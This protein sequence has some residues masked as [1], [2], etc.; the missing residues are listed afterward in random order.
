MATRDDVISVLGALAH[1]YP[2]TKLSEG[3][4]D[5]WAQML[6]DIPRGPLMAG[7][8]L[9]ICESRFMPSISE[10]RNAAFDLMDNPEDR[11]TGVEAWEPIAAALLNC[12]VGGPVLS[13]RA[14]R[15]L[16]ITSGDFWGL[17]ARIQSGRDGGTA[18]RARFIEAYDSIRKREIREDRS[19]PE[20]RKALNVHVETLAIESGD[21]EEDHV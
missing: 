19:H 16:A 9:L 20:V 11:L 1:A 6:S 18:D 4:V 10:V 7:I 2:S 15:A 8:K 3:G 5:L 21:D 13:G 17:R 12:P 14:H